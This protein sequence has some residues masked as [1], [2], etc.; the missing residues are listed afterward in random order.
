MTAIEPWAISKM[1]PNM[2]AIAGTMT[3]KRVQPTM[4]R[5]ARRYTK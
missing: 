3:V 5:I 1:A 2:D 4:W